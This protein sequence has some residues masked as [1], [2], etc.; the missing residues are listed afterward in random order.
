MRG[1]SLVWFGLT[2]AG[3]IMTAINETAGA[4]HHGNRIAKRAAPATH[5]TKKPPLTTGKPWP[6][7]GNGKNACRCGNGWETT[8]YCAK[9]ATGS[10]KP[11]CYDSWLSHWCEIYSWKE[12]EDFKVCCSPTRRGGMTCLS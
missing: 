5:T 7:D 4:A 10:A 9:M 6:N 11:Y 12:H 3:L 1:L 8:V 2:A